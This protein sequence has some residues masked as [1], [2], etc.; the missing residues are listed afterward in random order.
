MY[1]G[2]ESS[3]AQQCEKTRVAKEFL[4]PDPDL[5]STNEIHDK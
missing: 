3:N 5:V 4:V 2:P 1:G